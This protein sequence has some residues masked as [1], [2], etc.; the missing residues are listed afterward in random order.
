MARQQLPPAHARAPMRCTCAA[1]RSPAHNKQQHYQNAWNRASASCPEAWDSGNAQGADQTSH[2][3]LESK[4]GGW[5]AAY[6]SSIVCCRI[7]EV[8][9]EL[10]ASAILASS[11][12]THARPRRLPAR[13]KVQ[14]ALV[15]AQRLPLRECAPPHGLGALVGQGVVSYARSAQHLPVCRASA[16]GR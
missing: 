4:G 12:L 5:V 9:T 16:P 10:V 2:H 14:E 11:K 13:L 7:C 6:T 3:T 8:S 15:P 1:A